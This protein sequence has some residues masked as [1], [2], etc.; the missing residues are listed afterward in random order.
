MQ[1][2]YE[3]SLTPTYVSDWDFNMA[4][5]E[6]IQNGIDQQAVNFKM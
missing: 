1:Q 5:R 6:L 2:T 3:L 4:I